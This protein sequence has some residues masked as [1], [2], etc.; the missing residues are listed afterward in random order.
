M[1]LLACPNGAG[2]SARAAACPARRPDVQAD[3]ARLPPTGQLG[4]DLPAPV[5]LAL[6]E[7]SLEHADHAAPAQEGQVE[8]EARDIACREA[9]EKEATVPRRRAQSG[10]GVGTADRVV[11]D[12][13][14]DAAGKVAD[15]GLKVLARVVD[16]LVGPCSRQLASFSVLAAETITRAPI[17]W[18]SPTAA[19]L[20]PPA[21]PSTSRD[22]PGCTTARSFRAWCETSRRY[23]RPEVS[24]NPSPPGKAPGRRRPPPSP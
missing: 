24:V 6:D 8:P 22:S 17:K 19:S 3:V 14:T 5:W 11:D 21:A 1:A 20:T 23:G 13:G 12:V 16:G 7:R 18:S 9:D 10:L 15:A 2:G 4:Q